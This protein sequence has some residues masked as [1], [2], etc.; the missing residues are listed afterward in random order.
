M[1]GLIDAD[2]TYIGGKN[3]TQDDPVSGETKPCSC[4]VGVSVSMPA[5]YQLPTVLVIPPLPD[6]G[7]EPMHEDVECAFWSMMF[8]WI[9]CVGCVSFFVNCGALAGSRRLK[10]ARIG[11]V[12]SCVVGESY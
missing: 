9:C 5:F 1:I 12:I 11:C 6:V 2:G 3:S 7:P 10:Y 4:A 8:S